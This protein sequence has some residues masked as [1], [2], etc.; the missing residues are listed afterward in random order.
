MF[1]PSPRNFTS[2]P[3]STCL[4]RRVN[5]D[6]EYSGFEPANDLLGF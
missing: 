6:E 3:A 5:G 4:Y 2:F 1:H